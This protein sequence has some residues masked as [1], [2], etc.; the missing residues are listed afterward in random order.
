MKKCKVFEKFVDIDCGNVCEIGIV[1]VIGY[2]IVIV[3]ELLR[4]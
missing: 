2:R 3:V 1:I 4:L